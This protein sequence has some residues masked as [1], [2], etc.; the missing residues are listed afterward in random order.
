MSAGILLKGRIP[1]VDRGKIGISYS[2]GGGLVLVELGIARAFVELG[3]VP[4]VIAGA[5]AGALAG[6]AHALDV[7]KGTGI[8]MAV[9]VL[10]RVSNR[11]LGL[12]HLSVFERLISQRSRTTSLGDN[13][14]I[15]QLVR[16]G[17][18]QSLGLRNVTLGTFTGPDYPELMLVA[19]D[20]TNGEALWFS[21]ETPIEDA[22]IAS[23]AI[24]GVFPW[25]TM[26]KEGTDVIVVDGGVVSNQPLSNLVDEGCGTIYACAVGPTGPLPP[27]DQCPCQRPQQRAPDDAPIHEIGGRVRSAEAR[28]SGSRSPHSSRRGLSGPRIRLH[29]RADRADRR[30]RLRQNARLALGTARR[31]IGRREEE[32]RIQQKGTKYGYQPKP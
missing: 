7:R 10:G 5:S 30:R 3:I 8:D 25:R 4:A 13:H 27:T 16:D 9:D 18:A 17:F 15:G 20:V 11:F 29:P 6:T 2:G 32:Y 31:L 21:A 12:D 28:R 1:K 22:L 26:T 19:T 14:P 24:P 23:S